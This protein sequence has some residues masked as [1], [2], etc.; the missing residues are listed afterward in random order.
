M[1]FTILLLL[2]WR[3][4]FNVFLHLYFIIAKIWL[5]F[6][7]DD[8][9][10]SNFTKLKKKTKIL[11]SSTLA[12]LTLI[13]LFGE[14]LNPIFFLWRIWTTWWRGKN[15]VSVIFTK[16]FFWGKNGPKVARFW[17]GKKTRIRHNWT[18]GSRTLP[19]YN[20]IIKFFYLS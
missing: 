3:V 2:Y 6:L 16:G 1:K 9:H 10:I 18:T 15:K 20:R 7:M 13:I 17:G 8:C 12:G 4:L 19:K 11:Y 5:N 14:M